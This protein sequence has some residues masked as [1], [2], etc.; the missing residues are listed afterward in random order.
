MSEGS[1]VSWQSKEESVDFIMSPSDHQLGSSFVLVALRTVQ[2]LFMLS[3]VFIFPRRQKKLDANES[4][5]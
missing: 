3:Y 4:S 5:I 2:F 1:V